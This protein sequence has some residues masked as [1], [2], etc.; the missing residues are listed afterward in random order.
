M[1]LALRFGFN[2]ALTGQSAAAP[3]AQPIHVLG[4]SHRG[5]RWRVGESPNRASDSLGVVVARGEA[6]RSGRHAGTAGEL[7]LG[8]LAQQDVEELSRHLSG[9]V[10]VTAGA[11]WG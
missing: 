3:P 7:H 9:E 5:G 1:E 11:W 6:I 2:N 8:Q 4:S 10:K